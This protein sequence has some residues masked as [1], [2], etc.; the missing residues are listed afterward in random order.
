MAFRR[1][2]C[3]KSRP[4]HKSQL[5]FMLILFEEIAILAKFADGQMNEKNV[6]KKIPVTAAWN[7]KKNYAIGGR[8]GIFERLKRPIPN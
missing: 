1:V 7:L 8:F 5:P 3:S 4:D 6:N 2:T